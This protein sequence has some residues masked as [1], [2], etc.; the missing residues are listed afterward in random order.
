MP[1]ERDPDYDYVPP[2]PKPGQTTWQRK[3]TQCGE[4]GMKFEYG[5][6]YGFCCA[7]SRCPTGWGSSR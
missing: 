5:R 3:G 1:V 6:S 7:N 4:C 2:L